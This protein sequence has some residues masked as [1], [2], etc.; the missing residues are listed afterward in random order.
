M[1]LSLIL[2]AFTSTLAAST[3]FAA[4][5]NDNLV[6]EAPEVMVSSDRTGIYIAARLSAAFADDTN[7]DLTVVDTNVINEYKDISAI[8][9]LAIGYR[10]TDIFSAELEIGTGQQKIEA[11]TITALPARLDGNNAFGE[12]KLTYGLI[13][14]AAEYD[15]G[16]A[17]R[18]YLSA[19]LGIAQAEFE[20][21]GVTLAAA[22]GPLP[23]G[24]L[25]VMNDKDRS[26]AYQIGAGIVVDITDKI[27]L[28]A[29]YRYFA[30]DDIELTAVDGTVSDIT[31][32]Q[33]QALFGVRYSF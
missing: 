1:R 29:G 24:D 32:E 14:I 22:V 31:I 3:A 27:G 2:A 28:E 17:V 4:D 33:H 20:N 16:L 19:G 15:T 7:F 21:H 18:P 11:H 12:T 5:M 10:F 26:L 25:T 13:N 9:G 6:I 8:G 23:A 30:V